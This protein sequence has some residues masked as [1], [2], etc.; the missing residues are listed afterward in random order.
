MFDVGDVTQ[1]LQTGGPLVGSALGADD[2]DHHTAL[3]GNGGADSTT[4]HNLL[5]AINTQNAQLF[6]SN[7]G[8][9]LTASG[10]SGVSLFGG[11]G[12]DSLTADGVTGA[13]LFGVVFAGATLI[14]FRI[15]RELQRHEQRASV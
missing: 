1:R 10:G 3:A 15:L 14:S 5:E 4:N 11:T 6:G 13:S 12:N 7:G 2:F 9:S 8:D